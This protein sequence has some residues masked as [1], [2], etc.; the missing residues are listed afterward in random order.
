MLWEQCPKSLNQANLYIMTAQRERNA[1]P[2]ARLQDLLGLINPKAEMGPSEALN[3][4]N[5]RLYGTRSD[6]SRV[7]LKA[8]DSLE[9]PLGFTIR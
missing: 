9:V 8:N 2:E 5:F 7:V 4:A 3:T 1:P 6:A